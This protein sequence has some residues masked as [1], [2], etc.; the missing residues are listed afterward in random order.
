MTYIGV[1]DDLRSKK[2]ENNRPRIDLVETDSDWSGLESGQPDQG[3]DR[4]V[5]GPVNRSATGWA[6]L[7]SGQPGG[8]RMGRS[9]VRS[10][11]LATGNFATFRFLPGTIN[12]IRLAAGWRP[13]DRARNRAVRSGGRS[14]RVLDRPGRRLLLSRIPPA[15]PSRV[16][17]ISSCPAPCP[18]SRPS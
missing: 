16:H 11:G 7:W 3:P 15:P 17:E 8:N 5:W 9:M 2:Y 1:Q 13:V 10:T 4:P 18:A 6:G 12:L 14:D